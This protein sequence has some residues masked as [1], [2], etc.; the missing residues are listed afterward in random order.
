MKQKRILILI[1]AAAVLAVA[2]GVAHFAISKTA[3]RAPRMDESDLLAYN[4]ALT[5]RAYTSGWISQ[6][7]VLILHSLQIDGD[8]DAQAEFYLYQLPEGADADDF[9]SLHAGQLQPEDGLVHMGI[10]SCLIPTGEPLSAYDFDLS[11]IR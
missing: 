1:I 6:D 3:N 7:M 8:N 5:A 10:L 4:S 2:L 11:F 9:L